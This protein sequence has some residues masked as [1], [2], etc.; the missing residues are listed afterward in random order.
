M[1]RLRVPTLALPLVAATVHGQ[2][3]KFGHPITRAQHGPLPINL[4]TAL[5]LAH[6]RNLDV[7]LAPLGRAV[8]GG[9][10]ASTFAT[11]VLLPGVFALVMGRAGRANDSLDPYDPGSAEYVANG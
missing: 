7:Q 8:V 11:L 6:A 5:K 3:A 10:F 1:V 9:L 4:A 2:F